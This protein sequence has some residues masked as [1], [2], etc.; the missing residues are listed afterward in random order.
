MK[1]GGFPEYLKT[2]LPEVLM[3]AFNDIIIRDIAIRYNLKK[4]TVL[5]QLAVWLVSNTGKP[6]T[7]NSLRKIFQIRSSSSMMDY[8]SYFVDA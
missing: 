5:Q 4:S 2:G 1:S 7:G 8:I 3:N 6:M